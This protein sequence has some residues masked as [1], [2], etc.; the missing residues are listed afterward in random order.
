MFPGGP[1]MPM[2][3]MN[4][5]SGFSPFQTLGRGAQMAQAPARGAG[6]LLS[7]LF[8]KQGAG[9]AGAF[10]NMAGQSLQQGSGGF[11]S[12]LLANPG[13]MLNNVQKAIGV[14]N[15]VGPMV[16]QYGPMVRNIPSLIKL[17]K[18]FNSSDDSTTEEVV[19]EKEVPV[20]KKTP[21]EKTAVS[22]GTSKPKLY[23]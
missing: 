22:K 7:K 4:Q 8:S 23:I 11:L 17:Y 9:A 3:P 18:E 21:V 15:Q 16:Q 6:G 20:S 10:N 5:M 19:E 12:N 13:G 2:G 1:R 14:A